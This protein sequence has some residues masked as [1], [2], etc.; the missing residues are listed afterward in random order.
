MGE[1]QILHLRQETQNWPRAEVIGQR[2][3]LLDGVQRMNM[4]GALLTIHSKNALSP[5]NQS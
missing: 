5:L 4:P 2:F 1:N 3:V